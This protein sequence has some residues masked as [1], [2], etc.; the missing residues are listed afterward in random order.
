MGRCCWG[1]DSWSPGVRR[2]RYLGVTPIMPKAVQDKMRSDSYAYVDMVDVFPSRIDILRLP[3]LMKGEVP[4]VGLLETSV[5]AS[6]CSFVSCLHAQARGSV[7]EESLQQQTTL[8]DSTVLG[9]P[10]ST[11]MLGAPSRPA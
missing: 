9:Q 7:A 3:T 2:I 8:P 11:T 1:S 5:P 4:R 6:S 10:N